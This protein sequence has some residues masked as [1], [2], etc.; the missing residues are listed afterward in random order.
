MIH[1]PASDVDIQISRYSI[2][3]WKPSFLPKM[4]SWCSIKQKLR[5]KR[6]SQTS[7]SRGHRKGKIKTDQSD[8]WIR[9]TKLH[10]EVQRGI[11]CLVKHLQLSFFAK[12]VN[13]FLPLTLF[14]KQLRHRCSIGFLIRLWSSLTREFHQ[15]M[16]YGLI[17]IW[18]LLFI[19]SFVFPL[20]IQV[21]TSWTWIVKKAIPPFPK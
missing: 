9:N 20:G 7:E 14:A 5:K 15:M 18:W 21:H 17:T 1:R 10:I 19:G 13:G 4:H 12:I 11:Q 16:H 6:P 3:K 2:R 8:I